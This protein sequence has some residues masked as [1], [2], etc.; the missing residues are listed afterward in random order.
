MTKKNKTKGKMPKKYRVFYYGFWVL[1]IFGFGSFFGLFYLASTGGLGEM[2]DFRQLE[3]PNTN[4]ASQIISSD[5]KLLGKF[6]FGENRTPIE[7][8][9]LPKQLIDALIAEL[10][11]PNSIFCKAVSGV[12]KFIATSAPL[13]FLILESLSILKITSCPL[14]RE[15]FSISFPIF[16]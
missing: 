9:E 15:I 2:P 4:L 16:P 8:D 7:Y 13:I 5:N 14:A 11:K 3:N 12:Q 10:F 6:H 1:F